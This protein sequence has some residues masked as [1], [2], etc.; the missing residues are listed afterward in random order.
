MDI[1]K[2]T[3]ILL[4]MDGTLVRHRNKFILNMLER[5][6]DFIVRTGRLF[7]IFRLRLRRNKNIPRFFLPGD[8][9]GKLSAKRKTM[10]VHKT[11]HKMRR[12]DV[13]QIVRISSGARKFLE[14][15]QEYDIPMGLVSNG[16]GRGYGRDILKSFQ[17]ERFF[18]VAI[19]RE[20]YAFAKPYPDPLL[21]ALDG[22]G[23]PLRSD[24]VI[25]Y[26]GDRNKDVK[27][28]MAAHYYLSSR[29]DKVKKVVP[30]A[31]D[32]FS[33]A[34]FEAIKQGL[35]QHHLI[36]SFG[37]YTVLLEAM[38]ASVTP[39]LQHDQTKTEVNVIKITKKT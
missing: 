1:E 3:I 10:L 30:F 27:A 29:E 4:D 15:A 12:K 25:W 18:N 5:V 11:L 32:V 2:P 20:D 34:F 16:L 38:H 6:D 13:N 7:R 17:L 19:F 26:L 36:G 24:D 35:P 8:D 39:D 31:F 21:R 22:I 23:R 33:S 37:E 9:S 28:A 14:K